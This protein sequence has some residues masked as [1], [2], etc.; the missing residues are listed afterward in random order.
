LIN[1]LTGKSSIQRQVG[2]TTI[3]RG[4]NL[5]AALVVAM[6]LTRILPEETYGAYRKLWL[7]YAIL[8]PLAISTL[9]NSLYYRGSLK[10]GKPSTA[11]WIAFLYGLLLALA[12]SLINYWGAP[13]WAELLNTSVYE[14]AFRNFSFYI[15]FTIISGTAEPLFVLLKRKKWLLGYNIAYNIIEAAIII[16]V[17]YYNYILSDI[18][19]IMAAGPF[20]R[21]L[22]VI[23]LL[24]AEKV[25]IPLVS[26]LWQ[27]SPYFAKYGA[28]ILGTAFIGIAVHD[29]DKWIVGSFYES[30]ALYAI[31]SIGARKLPL[32]IITGS[33][34]TSL[35]VHYSSNL[36]ENDYDEVLRRIKYATN[37]LFLYL[38][39]VVLFSI[40]F[41][42]EL[43]VLIYEKY[44]ASAGI[45]RI[46]VLSTI[47]V[48]L[49]PNVVIMGKGHSFVQAKFSA[50]DLLLNIILSLWLIQVIG[51]Q[52][53]AL[54]T[55]IGAIFYTVL[56][57][58]YCRRTFNI[59][60]KSFLP[61]RKIWPI[62]ISLGLYAAGG[63]FLHNT[64]DVI[65]AAVTGVG[66]LILVIYVHY[67]LLVKRKII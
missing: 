61:G 6:V 51:F 30:D 7:V 64:L 38:G 43:M 20:L 21:F 22:F 2:A 39:P 53:P 59:P 32:S 5:F 57:I 26:D 29:V 27:E 28:G 13:F 24:V 17:F 25:T 37:R 50:I 36:A 18:A 4:I 65:A 55:F 52:G 42:E 23:F 62:L 45:F 44:A 14:E 46:Y 58:L 66:L 1:Y 8:G 9:V 63:L 19:L 10:E 40:I 49:F 56:Q 47:S 15:F 60:V 12:C 11:I 67:S 33:I 48:F 31:Y 35:I 54:A 16:T 34:A 41:A 3:A